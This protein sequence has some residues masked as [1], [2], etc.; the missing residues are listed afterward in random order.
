MGTSSASNLPTQGTEEGIC[1]MAIE[2]ILVSLSDLKSCEFAHEEENLLA[3][4][5]ER[6]Q[7]VG[8]YGWC[9][10]VSGANPNMLRKEIIGALKESR[11]RRRKW[12]KLG[13]GIK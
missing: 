12:K 8:G 13:R 5:K 2:M 6:S 1:A 9:L 4:F 7:E 3:W 11:A 10:L